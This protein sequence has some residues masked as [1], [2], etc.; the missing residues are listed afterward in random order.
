VDTCHS[1]VIDHA[2]LFFEQVNQSI[3]LFL[4]E[5]STSRVMK[6]CI[7]NSAKVRS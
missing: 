2:D 4:C 6:L 3:L 7:D 1:H 5:T